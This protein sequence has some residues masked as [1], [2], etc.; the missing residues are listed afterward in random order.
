MLEAVHLELPTALDVIEVAEPL[1]R[2]AAGRCSAPGGTAA[3]A[4]GC[5]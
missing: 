1:Y 3:A 5:N 4:A 2:R